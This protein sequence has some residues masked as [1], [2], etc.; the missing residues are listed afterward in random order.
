ME[1]KRIIQIDVEDIPRPFYVTTDDIEL[2]S[3]PEK[4]ASVRFLAPLDNMLWD[5]DMVKS[6]F[7]FEYSWEVYTPAAKRRYGYYV[8]PV[9]Y[10]N[11]LVARF[12]PEY[13][14]TAKALTIK[15]W[16]W[17]SGVKHTKKLEASIEHEKTRFNKFL[18]ESYGASI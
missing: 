14:K 7:D 2:F 1:Q 13:Y 15:N 17:E 16:W 4:E 8:L 6:L 9:L 11:N 10:G 5:R 3:V 18:L 12:E